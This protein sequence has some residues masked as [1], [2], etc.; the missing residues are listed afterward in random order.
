MTNRTVVIGAG[1]GGLAAAIR[2]A[3][4]GH[5]VV[6]LERQSGPGGKMRPVEIAGETYDSGPTVLTMLWVFEELFGEAGSSLE[7]HVT[8]EQLPILARHFWTGD[9]TLDLRRA[10]QHSQKMPGGSMILCAMP[11]CLSNAQ[12]RSA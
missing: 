7:E 5:Q 12:P 8:L 2:L 1:V 3:A 6:V 9:H 11:S 10:T 4:R